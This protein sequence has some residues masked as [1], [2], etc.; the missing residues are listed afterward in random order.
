MVQ[1][2][3]LSSALA[4]T[5]DVVICLALFSSVCKTHVQT[6]LLRQLMQS[7]S[8]SRLVSARNASVMALKLSMNCVPYGERNLLRMQ[9]TIWESAI[10]Q[11]LAPEN[12]TRKETLLAFCSLRPSSEKTV[13]S[14]GH[15]WLMWNETQWYELDFFFFLHEPTNEYKSGVLF[16]DRVT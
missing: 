9:L 8:E 12:K 14:H 16:P 11:N 3:L 13:W 6:C 1:K 15:F 10:G 7:D 4:L 2:L 5:S